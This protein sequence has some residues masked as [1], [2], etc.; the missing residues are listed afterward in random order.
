[1]SERETHPETF[2]ET[3]PHARGFCLGEMQI[4]FEPQK[5][6]G[7]SSNGH[8]SVSHPSRYSTIEELFAIRYAPGRKVTNLWVWLL[9]PEQQERTHPYSLHMDVIPPKDKIG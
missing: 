8:L 1:M 7:G 6:A 5:L 3:Y 4:I 2:R 9:K